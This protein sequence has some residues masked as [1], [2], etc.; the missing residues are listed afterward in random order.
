ML[1]HLTMQSAEQLNYFPAKGG[2]SAYYSPYAIIKRRA[3]DYDRH[4]RYGFG[5]YVQAFNENNP[6]N[7][8][9]PRTLDCIYLRPNTNRQGGH[10][11]MDL[12]TGRVITRS[13]VTVVPI[14][15]GVI[16]AVERMAARDGILTLKILDRNKKLLNPNVWFA[17]VGPQNENE[18]DDEDDEEYSEPSVGHS[19]TRQHDDDLDSRY[20]SIDQDELAELLE[21]DDSDFGYEED[22]PI[23][24]EDQVYRTL[25][26][27]NV[28]HTTR[29][30][31]D[32]RWTWTYVTLVYQDSTW[33]KTK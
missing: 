15:D 21:E 9:A 11:L 5:S 29:K 20:K 28:P 19:K 6:T 13:R 2:I 18:S 17:G 22:R 24:A 12:A 30:K 32:R 8:N 3:I 10:M 7:T 25:E 23:R 31:M 33:M 1:K 14:S 4:L 16:R 26:E 27:Y